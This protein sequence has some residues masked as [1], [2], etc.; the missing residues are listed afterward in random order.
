MAANSTSFSRGKSGNPAGRPPGIRDRRMR[1]LDEILDGEAEGITRK[2]VELAKDGDLTA[3]RICLDRV[4]PPRKDRTIPFALPKLETAADAKEAAAAI[5]KA[6][7]E[8]D[9]T[10][11]EAADVSKLLDNFARILEATDFQT[12]LEAL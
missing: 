7:A 3:I 8:G 5:V 10:P 11:G 9:I 6:V 4:L 1:A 2:A 12:R